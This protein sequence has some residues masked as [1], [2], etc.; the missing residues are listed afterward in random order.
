MMQITNSG[1]IKRIMVEPTTKKEAFKKFEYYWY[2]TEWEDLELAKI[3][4]YLKN[5]SKIPIPPDFRKESVRKRFF[6]AVREELCQFKPDDLNPVE[7]SL[8][9]HLLQI[10]VKS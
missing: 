3:E 7:H 10:S 9:T 8:K 6:E 4:Y 1:D 5:Y 2:T